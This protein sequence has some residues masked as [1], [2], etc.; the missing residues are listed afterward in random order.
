M[1]IKGKKNTTR[2]AI[3]LSIDGKK[4]NKEEDIANHFNTYFTSVAHNL[5]EK[6]PPSPG[7]YGSE[8][9]QDF[10]ADRGVS[11]QFFI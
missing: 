4:I 8:H 5:V 9:I 6:L 1:R 10:Y 3:T 7:L 11:Q 2:S